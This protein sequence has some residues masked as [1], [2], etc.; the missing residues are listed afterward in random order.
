MYHFLKAQSKTPSYLQ[1]HRKNKDHNN[2]QETSRSVLS[3]RLEISTRILDPATQP[4]TQP[5]PD[6]ATKQST[7]SKPDPSTKQSTTSKPDPATKQSKPDPATKQSKP[8]PTTKPNQ[9]VTRN[10]Q[11]RKETLTKLQPTSCKDANTS[12]GIIINIS[13]CELIV[14]YGSNTFHIYVS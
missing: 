4:S 13:S 10:S 12:A 2:Q 3:T 14:S 8:D 5:K 1:Q 9:R 11:R 7:T 6:P